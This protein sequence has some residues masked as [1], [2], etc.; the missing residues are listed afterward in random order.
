MLIHQGDTNLTYEISSMSH[1]RLDLYPFFSYF[2][3]RSEY[4]KQHGERHNHV[5]MEKRRTMGKAH[6]AGK[7]FFPMALLDSLF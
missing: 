4:G 6:I 7:K 1:E 2:V 5:E 3:L